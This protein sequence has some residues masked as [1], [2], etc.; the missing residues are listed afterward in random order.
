M[1]EVIDIS[2]KFKQ[3]QVKNNYSTLLVTYKDI[4]TVDTEW[5][6]NDVLTV[7]SDKLTFLE[8]LKLYE[9]MYQT[10]KIQ[11]FVCMDDVLHK[12]D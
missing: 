5:L 9:E 6:Q 4:N 7:D 2:H 11:G 3:K 10:R 8:A 12:K 1:A